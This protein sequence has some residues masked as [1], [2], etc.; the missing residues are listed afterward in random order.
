MP[1][2]PVFGTGGTF[3]RCRGPHF[4]HDHSLGSLDPAG[5][6]PSGRSSRAWS[7]SGLSSLLLGRLSACFCSLLLQIHSFWLVCFYFCEKYQTCASKITR[8]L[9]WNVEN[10]T[11]YDILII[12]SLVTWHCDFNSIKCAHSSISHSFTRDDKA[13]QN[14]RVSVSGERKRR[15]AAENSLTHF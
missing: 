1:L 15:R 8:F 9:C 14:T 3:L 4:L 10:A 7:F 2:N 5:L 11:A 6:P 12:L 13:Q